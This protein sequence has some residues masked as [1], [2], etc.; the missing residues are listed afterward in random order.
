MVVVLGGAF[1]GGVGAGYFASLVRDESIRSYESMKKD[2]YNYEETSDLYFANDV[3]L[4]KLRTDLEREEVNIR[5]C[6][7]LSH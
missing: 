2:I 5:R 3:Y 7:R 1:A 6:C 4:G